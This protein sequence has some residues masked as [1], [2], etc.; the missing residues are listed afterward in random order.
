MLSPFS[1]HS[2][3][4]LGSNAGGKGY[5][6]NAGGLQAT[7]RDRYKA[8]EKDSN[9]GPVVFDK[10]K[11]DKDAVTP[12]DLG[13]RAMVAPP[14]EARRNVVV[15]DE[16]ARQKDATARQELERMRAVEAPKQ[17]AT[18][19]A[20]SAPSPAPAPAAPAIPSPPQ[21]PQAPPP[22]A[23]VAAPAAV[24]VPPAAAP[25]APSYSEP[26]L[27]SP[28]PVVPKPRFSRFETLEA[29]NDEADRAKERPPSA[30][31]GGS[32]LH[33]RSK[34]APEAV[35]APPAAATAAPPAAP[36]PPPAVPPTAASAGE[37][38]DPLDAYGD[39]VV[40]LYT[41]MTR[42]QLA[43]VATRKVVTQAQALGLPYVELDGT[44]AT[45]KAVRTALW[46]RAGAK[47][48]TYPILYVGATGFAASGE[49]VQDLID[50]G[51]LDAKLGGMATPRISTAAELPPSPSR[52]L[53]P[54]AATAPPTPPVAV[55]AVPAAPPPTLVV[56]RPD[57]PIIAQLASLASRL[58][59][60][61]QVDVAAPA[62]DL[63]AAGASQE[64]VAATVEALL[65]LVEMGA[66]GLQMRRL[67]GLAQRLENVAAR[68]GGGAHGAGMPPPSASPSGQDASMPQMMQVLEGTTSRL[69][70]L[71]S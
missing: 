49:E 41:S 16:A 36:P 40:I 43:T 39:K 37:A 70:A 71:V 51:T 56:V 4:D 27:A 46:A 66:D 63:T 58:A 26:Q 48:G 6:S 1:N 65:G 2:A 30:R 57:A 11:K 69:E 31:S 50:A 25:D 42:D 22:A 47:P 7:A 55:A 34:P 61:G 17:A 33:S 38:A 21:E 9:I 8:L 45:H 62:V 15:R 64:Q 67:E 24:S 12:M 68:R 60:L 3:Q 53:P 29:T 10:Y 32:R 54:P 44:D 18:P 52:A 35:A 5:Q 28:E 59:V 19:T 23:P 20:T 13:G 14:T